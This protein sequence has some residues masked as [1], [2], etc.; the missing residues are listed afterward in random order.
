MHEKRA[1]VRKLSIKNTMERKM[2]TKEGKGKKEIGITINV[3][4]N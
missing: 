3:S 4:Q 2:L 1:E